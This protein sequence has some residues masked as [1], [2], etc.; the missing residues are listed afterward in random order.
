MSVF[1]KRH[2]YCQHKTKQTYFDQL[3]KHA[4]MK[5]IIFSKENKVQKIVQT[6]YENEPNNDEIEKLNFY[7]I[8]MR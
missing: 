4:K 5:I 2:N 7:L 1:N 3:T 8:A 6:K